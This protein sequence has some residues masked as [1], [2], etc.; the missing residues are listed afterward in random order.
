MKNSKNNLIYILTLFSIFFIIYESLEI[1]RLFSL[2]SDSKDVIINI[3]KRYN[4]TLLSNLTHKNIGEQNLSNKELIDIQNWLSN[5]QDEIAKINQKDIGA[6]FLLLKKCWSITVLQKKDIKRCYSLY[7]NI[8]D[9]IQKC[10]KSWLK[11]LRD[12]ILLFILTTII[13][14]ILI[15]KLAKIYIDRELQENIIYDMESR[16]YSYYYCIDII[17][18]LCSQSDR[19]RR[20]I[21]AIF[22]ELPILEKRYNLDERKKVLE[23]VGEFLTSTIRLSDI[24]C[25]Y[26]QSSFLILLPNTHLKENVPLKRIEEGLD[27]YIK[28]IFP[29]CQI[30]ISYTIRSIEEDCK[31]FIKRTAEK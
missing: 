17:K 2:I 29:D 25:R 15:F 11:Q 22:I 18:K 10:S 19:T 27:K 31:D 1:Y 21:S 4:A 8:V 28:D 12:T 6:E 20:P 16:L 5:N 14:I 30:K 24:A 7:Q 26:S 9:S 3:Q 23:S 13:S